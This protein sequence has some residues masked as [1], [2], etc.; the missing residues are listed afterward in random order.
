M[1]VEDYFSPLFFL[2]SS[3]EVEQARLLQE[4]SSLAFSSS[5][6]IAASKALEIFLR[7]RKGRENS[8]T[9]AKHNDLIAV[10]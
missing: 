2:F 1:G 8:K 5:H 9:K 10:L 7:R 3:A 6:T 4:P